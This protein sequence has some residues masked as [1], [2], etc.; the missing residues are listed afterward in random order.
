MSVC[1]IDQYTKLVYPCSS[2]VNSVH[3]NISDELKDDKL[4]AAQSIKFFPESLENVRNGEN[5]GFLPLPHFFPKSNQN[6]R[7]SGK[8]LKRNFIHKPL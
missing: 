5:A 1:G 2:W 7:L 4:Y 3:N 8:G 6:W